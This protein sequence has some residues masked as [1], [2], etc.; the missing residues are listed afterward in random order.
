MFNP[1]GKGLEIGPSHNPLMRKADGFD[2]EVLVYLDAEGLRRKYS[3]AGLDVSAVEA[4]DFVSDGRPM[5]EVIGDRHR[6]DWIVASHVIE[7][8]PDLVSF[9]V[10]C[11]ALL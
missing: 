5:T 1:A 2:V 7:H 4:V 10:D 11:E 6:Y 9:L 8:V 3:G